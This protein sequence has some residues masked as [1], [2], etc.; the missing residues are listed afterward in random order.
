MQSG[1]L[2]GHQ[3]EPEVG[4]GNVSRWIRNP[5]LLYQSSTPQVK[6]LLG[7]IS[8]LIEDNRD[9]HPDMCGRLGELIASRLNDHQGNEAP[10]TVRTPPPESSR[11]LIAAKLVFLT[12]NT[13]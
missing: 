11:Q 2:L 7:D 3:D 6:A 13:K 12:T 9:D 1:D 10:C 4:A 8:N 5:S